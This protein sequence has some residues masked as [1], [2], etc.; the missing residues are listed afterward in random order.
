MV[1]LILIQQGKGADAGAAFGSGAS[2]TV[3]G[4]RGAASFLTRTTAIL[5]A[6]FFSTSMVLAYLADMGNNPKQDIMDVPEMV[7]PVS[8]L[9]TGFQDELMEKISDLPSD[10]PFPST[11]ENSLDSPTTESIDESTPENPSKPAENPPN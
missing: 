8:D 9:P 11:P 5:A 3:F 1:G 7:Q 4:A 6:L 10:L 2:G